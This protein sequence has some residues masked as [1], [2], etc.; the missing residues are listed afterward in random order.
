MPIVA[1]QLLLEALSAGGAI[2]GI[3]GR[4]V[5][6]DLNERRVAG[7]LAGGVPGGVVGRVKIG[8]MSLE[9]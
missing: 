3:D 1:I 2:R 4:H 9:R 7:S 5:A 6:G 8:C